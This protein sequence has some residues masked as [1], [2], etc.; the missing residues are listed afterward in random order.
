MGLT[1]EQIESV[2]DAHTETVDA[3][4]SER[5]KYKTDAEELSNAQ[6][7]L[8]KIKSGTDWKAEHDKLKKEFDD[9]K[10]DVDSK[11]TLNKVKAAY[12]KL[13]DDKKIGKEDGDLIMLGTDFNG[14]KLK[15]DGTLDNAESLIKEIESKY[16]RYI[17]TTDTRGQKVDTPP[18][19]NNGN[20]ANPRAAELAKQYHERRY[21]ATT[22]D[23]AN[24]TNIN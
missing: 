24:K 10:A 18:T 7:E 9:Y 20:G 21:G 13:L 19:Q 1:D 23:G 16:A 22:T 5:D 15:N 17:P 6:K 12:R 8:D 11:E 4:K 3:L 2:I 14:K